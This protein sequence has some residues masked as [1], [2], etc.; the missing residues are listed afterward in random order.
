M[1][2]RYLIIN[3]VVL[4]LGALIA[5]GSVSTTPP[6]LP[7]TAE[8]AR[9]GQRIA[10]G[11]GACGHCHNVSGEPTAP[12]AGG[13][14]LQDKFGPV[15]SPNITLAASGIGS[16]SEGD[17]LHLF[18]AY[19]RP[20]GEMVAP[21]FHSGIEWISDNDVGAITTYIR[22]LP[23]VDNLVE[24]R[25]LSFID[26][27]TTGFFDS[28]AEVRGLVP[29]IP[30]NFK[31][32]YGQYLVDQV[33]RCG[34]CHSLPEGIVTSERY[35]AGGQ[36]IFFDGASKIAPDITSSTE[37][38][39]GGWSADEMK[40]FLMTGRTRDGRQV[41][42]RFC[43]VRFYRRATPEEIDAVVTYLRT[44]PSISD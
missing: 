18:R 13:R 5:C 42:S 17:L 32:E 8:L 44:V 39:L 40:N 43:P 34:S 33:A 41:D 9:Q 12:L 22:S 38:G 25:E 29:Q 1:L 24:H 30:R 7:A 36:E 31:V 16:W 37:S 2:I 35:M 20:N 23:A 28:M 14:L 21:A 10:E 15:S 27:N 11:L 19:R 6:P 4:G 3:G 26:R